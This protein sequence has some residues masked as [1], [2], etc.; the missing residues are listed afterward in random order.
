MTLVLMK[1]FPSQLDEVKN[2]RLS[3]WKTA[4]FFYTLNSLHFRGPSFTFQQHNVIDGLSET[5]WTHKSKLFP[6]H[7]KQIWPFFMFF[8]SIF[9]PSNTLNPL[10][11]DIW[12]Y[13]VGMMRY[14][15]FVSKKFS[16]S[17][18]TFIQ[19]RLNSWSTRCFEV[20]HGQFSFFF[21]C[22]TNSM[23]KRCTEDNED[24]TISRLRVWW[25]GS[26][27]LV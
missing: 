1:L 14:R 17:V 7:T 26:R 5:R 27:L 10:G 2:A 13:K 25:T 8:F 19:S 12:Q 22:S 9:V 24:K 21:A 20:L 6:L 4:C 15:P 11:A 23:Q 18:V 16:V 3:S